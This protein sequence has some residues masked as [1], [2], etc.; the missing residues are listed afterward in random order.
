MRIYNNNIKDFVYI[1][2][3][4]YRSGVN[5]STYRYYVKRDSCK[6][7]KQSYFTY[8]SSPAI[9]CCKSCAQSGYNNNMFGKT[10]SE[11]TRY[12]MSKAKKGKYV[13]KNNPMYGRKKPEWSNKMKTNNPTKF[14]GVLEK[15]SITKKGKNNP[16]Y[17]KCGSLAPNWRG[18]V[19]CEPYCFEWSSKEFKEFIKERDN[20]ECQN[21]DC[22]GTS[23]KLV[24]H[25]IDYNKKNCGPENLITLCVS[26]NSRANYKRVYWEIFYKNIIRKY[27]ITGDIVYEK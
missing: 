18:G 12:K 14:P 10:M 7:C 21:P 26:C 13:G 5:R 23:S 6:Y 15:I 2:D 27:F 1:G 24:V 20:Y 22:W 16:M 9:F 8:K 3:G 11:E 25:H 17:G 4:V 19:S